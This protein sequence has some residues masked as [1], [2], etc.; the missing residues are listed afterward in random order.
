MLKST[1]F[2]CLFVSFVAVIST[3]LSGCANQQI[4]YTQAEQQQISQHQAI[5]DQ[6]QQFVHANLFAGMIQVWNTD[7]LAWNTYLNAQLCGAVD[8]AKLIA[9]MNQKN[10]PV[11]VS[12]MTEAASHQALFLEPSEQ[13]ALEDV[14]QLAYRLFSNS[15]ATGYTRQ[16]GLADA[17]SPGMQEELCQGRVLADAGQDSVKSRSL[18]WSSYTSPILADN[19]GLIPHAENGNQAFQQLLQ[20]Q[21]AQFDALVYSHAYQQS[22]AYQ[23]LF[24]EVNKYENVQSYGELVGNLSE[25]GLGGLNSQNHNDFAYLILS[26]GYHWGMLSVLAVLEEE[27][28]RLHDRKKQQA[29]LEI[30]T[31]T[32]EI[33]ANN[34]QG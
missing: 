24:F 30:K 8:K 29:A 18:R 28:P 33:E 10:Q 15:Y 23:V 14:A 22:E 19:N 3:G 11:F 12:K 2:T 9:E 7:R 5:V 26:S 31:I 34:Q 17:L 6:A 4:V 20:Q 1:R 16:V 25:T 27:Y 21:Y 32:E 13:A